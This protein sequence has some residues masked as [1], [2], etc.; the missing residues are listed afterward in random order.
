M[1]LCS[2]CKQAKPKSEFYPDP[3]VGRDLQS[4][5]KQCNKEKQREWR[6]RHPDYAK[7]RQST[8]YAERRWVSHLKRT[9]GMHSAE[10]QSL[11]AQQGGRC[12]ICKT[13]TP[14][15]KTTRFHVDHSHKTGQVRGLLCSACN[16]MLGY[17]GDRAD[18]LAAAAKYLEAAPITAQVAAEFIAAYME[19]LG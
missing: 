6:A 15:G 7:S 2:R 1:K 19:T 4:N 3:R 16:R 5:C 12:A 8:I 9:Y 14:G 10:Y 18:V 11:L 17:A 13:E